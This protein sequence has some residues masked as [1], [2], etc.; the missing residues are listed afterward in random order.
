MD[1]EGI[2]E[3]F[4]CRKCKVMA[5][6]SFINRDN[7]FV[8]CPKCKNIVRGQVARNMLAEY[9]RY[10]AEVVFIQKT[11]SRRPWLRGLSAE[12]LHEKGLKSIEEIIVP[13]FEFFIDLNE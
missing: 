8:R 4:K 9:A 1:F 12:Q 7:I 5:K 2:E 13:D 6:A 10:D 3:R 11:F